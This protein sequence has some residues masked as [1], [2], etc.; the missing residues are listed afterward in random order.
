MSPILLEHKSQILMDSDDDEVSVYTAEGTATLHNTDSW[1]TVDV[2][3]G[4][5][6]AISSEGAFDAV[7]EFKE[8]EL[9]DDLSAMLQAVRQDEPEENCMVISLLGRSDPGLKTIRDFRDNVLA[10]SS[11]GKKVI[12]LFYENNHAMAAYIDESPIA[13]KFLKNLTNT[14][15]P[16][17]ACFL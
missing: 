5:K 17:L 8:S 2:T 6:M 1:D 4:H 9:D 10:K 12:S 16:V 14:F 15:M 3:T 7:V 13:R 11:T